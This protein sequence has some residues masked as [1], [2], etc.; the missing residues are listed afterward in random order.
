MRP[1]L[2]RARVRPAD[3]CGTAPRDAVLNSSASQSQGAISPMTFDNP[4]CDDYY[5]VEF[6]GSVNGVHYGYRRETPTSTDQGITLLFPNLAPPNR[7]L[8]PPTTCGPATHRSGRR[9][10]LRPL[11]HRSVRCGLPGQRGL[12]AYNDFRVGLASRSWPRTRQP[13]SVQPPGVSLDWAVG[14]PVEASDRWRAGAWLRNESA[15]RYA[16]RMGIGAGARVR[17][18]R[19]LGALGALLSIVLCAEAGADSQASWLDWSAPPECPTASD[20]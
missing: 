8:Y 14:E 18:Q 7:T 17:R 5:I 10:H 20:S 11:A 9:D 3:D 12:R 2:C 6:D 19:A 13:R 1:G 4:G 15:T 16:R